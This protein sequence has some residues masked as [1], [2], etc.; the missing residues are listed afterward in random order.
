MN[1]DFDD[2]KKKKLYYISTFWRHLVILCKIFG[3]NFVSELAYTQNFIQI[4]WKS[5]LSEHLRHLFK[6]FSYCQ[7]MWIENSGLNPINIS[8]W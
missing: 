8:M 4:I 7:S 2:L 6:L 5:F 1:V 3:T